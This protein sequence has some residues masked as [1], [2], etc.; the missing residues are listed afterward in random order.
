MASFDNK[1]SFAKEP[2]LCDQL[3]VLKL[4]KNQNEVK[5]KGVIRSKN[6]SFFK[7]V[8]SQSRTSGLEDF[9]RKHYKSENRENRPPRVLVQA[10]SYV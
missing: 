3:S 9:P 4:F 5:Q 1:R 8:G 10:P 2:F 7:S 6:L